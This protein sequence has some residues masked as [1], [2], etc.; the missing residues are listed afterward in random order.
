[1]AASMG[2]RTNAR[3]GAKNSAKQPRS[4]T[5]VA[6][7]RTTLALPRLLDGNLEIFCLREGRMKTE[8]V[9][10]AISTFLRRKGV[11]PDKLPKVSW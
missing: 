3:R 5:V 8:V 10:E 7:T 6:T 2:V 11:R 1:M 9:V 4:K